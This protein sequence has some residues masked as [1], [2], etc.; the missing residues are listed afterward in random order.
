[1]N[2]SKSETAAPA[3]E[4]TAP[5]AA[6]GT[7]LESVLEKIMD[8]MPAEVLAALPT[9]PEKAGELFAS[10]VEIPA[11]ID[12]LSRCTLAKSFIGRDANGQFEFDA[13]AFENAWAYITGNG[14]ESEQENS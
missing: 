10:L 7:G 8:Q 3:T 6:P 9:V 2:L 5:N 4:E 12:T 13:P 1:M 11:A 14:P